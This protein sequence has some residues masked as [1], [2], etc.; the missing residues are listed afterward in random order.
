MG[1]PAMTRSAGAPAVG[2]GSVPELL[3]ACHGQLRRSGARRDC[4]RRQDPAP[5]VRP[6]QR[7][8]AAPSGQRLGG[9][10]PPLLSRI[11]TA[12]VLLLLIS[13]RSSSFLPPFPRSGLCCP[14][15]STARNGRGI[16]KA[17]TPDAL[18]QTARFLRLPRP[19]VPTFRPQP[20]DPPHDRFECSPRQSHRLFQA[21]PS[22][23]K[24]AAKSRR[25]RFV[26]QRTA[27]SPPVALH[28]A[29]RQRSYLGLLG[30]EQPRH[31]LAPCK[32]SVLADALMADLVHHP[33]LFRCMAKTWVYQR[34]GSRRHAPP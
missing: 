27:G 31:G 3:S 22:M 32:Q 9:W 8:V 33:R 20:R 1:S 30:C 21:S 15:L 16:T 24:L 6:S 25:S 10:R 34:H 17:L 14:P 19:A 4:H 23:S 12:G 26:I 2:S 5:L 28:P 7:Q 11:D 29:L 18:T 13:H